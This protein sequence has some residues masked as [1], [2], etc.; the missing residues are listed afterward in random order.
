MSKHFRKKKTKEPI[1]LRKFF[2]SSKHRIGI[3]VGKYLV[4]FDNVG[5][6]QVHLVEQGRFDEVRPVVIWKINET[7]GRLLKTQPIYGKAPNDS[8]RQSISSGEWIE[9]R[10][11]GSWFI[12]D[13]KQ[14]NRIAKKFDFYKYQE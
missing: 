6:S 8:Y 3:A 7:M 4:G 13:R 14:A 10:V 12:V 11:V 5:G 1:P 2:E 9:N